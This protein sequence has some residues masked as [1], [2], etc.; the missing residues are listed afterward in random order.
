MFIVRE[1]PVSLIGFDESRGL[2]V[3]DTYEPEPE[4][5]A[6]PTPCYCDS[7]YHPKGH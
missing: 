1:V 5:P 7:A 4:A 2:Y 6:S 3:F